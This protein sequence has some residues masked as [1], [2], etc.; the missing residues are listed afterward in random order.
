MYTSVEGWLYGDSKNTDRGGR[1]IDSIYSLGVV[2]QKELRE[3]K[4]KINISNI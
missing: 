3:I 2:W 4:E 1:D